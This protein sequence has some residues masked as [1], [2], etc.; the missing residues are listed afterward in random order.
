MASDFLGSDV[1]NQNAR[2]TPG[3]DQRLSIGRK[4][5]A[6]QEDIFPVL[7]IDRRDRAVL[8]ASLC[9]E[10]DDAFV[11]CSTSPAGKPLAVG[12]EFQVFGPPQLGEL[13]SRLQV[14]HARS[15]RRAD[16]D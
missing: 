7:G 4:A 8:L 13:F 10:E 6:A 16:G 12:R 2:A 9:I 14:P 11:A 15:I 3:Y 5:E 1:V